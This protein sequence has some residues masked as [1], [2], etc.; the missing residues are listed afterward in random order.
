[1]PPPRK[2]DLL[3]PELKSFLQDALKQRGFAGYE[4]LADELNFMLEEEGLTLRI[5]KSALHSYGQEY[6]EFVKYQDEASSWAAE[7]M[8][9]NGLE[10]EAQ[11]HNILFQMITTLAFKVM[12]TQMSKDGKDIDPKELHFIGKM[13]KDVMS[14][15]GIREKMKTDER[16][17]V[18]DEAAQAERARITEAL[19][20]SVASG[21]VDLE[22]AQKAREIMGFA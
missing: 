14:S 9:D 3:P 18:A 12:Q 5:G 2:V 13:L 10:E 8:N 6:S 1:M 21:D 7:W 20:H 4:D 22:A 16:A 15:S 19:D 17:R 11:R